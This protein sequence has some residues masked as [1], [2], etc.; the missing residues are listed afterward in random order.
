[1]YP[2]IKEFGELLP[3]KSKVGEFYTFNVTSV[4][5]CL[6]E[7]RSEIIRFSDGRIMHIAQYHFFHEP[8]QNAV[9]FRIP[10]FLKEVY[11]TDR[12][13]NK[14]KEH[15]LMGLKLDPIWDTDN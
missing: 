10:Q 14:A 5:D 1:M 9:I 11:I 2:L 8:L 3:L 13:A 7:E 12:F 4:I 6:D 15:G